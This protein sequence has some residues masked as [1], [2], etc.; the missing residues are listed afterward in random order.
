MIEVFFSVIPPQSRA[1][2][3]VFMNESNYPKVGDE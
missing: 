1:S 3:E 2:T